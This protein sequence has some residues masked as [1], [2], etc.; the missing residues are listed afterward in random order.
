MRLHAVELALARAGRSPLREEAAVLVELGDA[1][2]RADAVGDVDVA[3]AIPRDVGRTAEAGT[4]MPAPRH[5]RDRRV[6][7]RSRR[8]RRLRP[9]STGARQRRRPP[10]RSTA[11]SA[12]GGA[13]AAR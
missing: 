4:R 1:V 5:R 12:A 6:R 2:V 3:G 13:R 7:R 10:P 9:A 11:T 8:D